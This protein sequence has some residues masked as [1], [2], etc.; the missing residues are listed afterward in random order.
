MAAQRRCRHRPLL[1]RPL[2]TARPTRVFSFYLT[3]R[4]LATLHVAPE[5]RGARFKLFA[6]RGNSEKHPHP[7]RLGKVEAD[8]K[9][10][11]SS[12]RDLAATPL[13]VDAP[14]NDSRRADR[15]R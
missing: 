3:W 11:S 12:R 14:A 5:P 4:S 13:D 15:L 2:D 6:L 9:R 8:D 1:H 10:A 7:G